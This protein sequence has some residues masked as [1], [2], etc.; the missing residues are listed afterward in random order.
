M[1]DTL[2]H[3]EPFMTGEAMAYLS[4][5]GKLEQFDLETAL[6]TPREHLHD[7]HIFCEI[8]E[9]LILLEDLSDSCTDGPMSSVTLHR[10]RL[11]VTRCVLQAC[12]ILP[13]TAA[14]DD[15]ELRWVLEHC[16]RDHEMFFLSGLA[17]CKGLS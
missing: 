2:D 16:A 14:T 5:L 4:L 13:P 10:L 11:G 6:N 1:L 15:A 3:P 17:V 12:G 8:I 9:A 7:N